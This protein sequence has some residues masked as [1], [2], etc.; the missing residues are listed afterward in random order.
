MSARKK[1]E[2]LG[3]EYIE[4][5]DSYQIRGNTYYMR[6]GYIVESVEG[7]GGD[8]VSVKLTDDYA[9][10]YISDAES[11]WCKEKARKAITVL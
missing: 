7:Y 11:K 8:V 4:N 10:I 6:D 1:L 5:L 9:E 3:Y 2:E